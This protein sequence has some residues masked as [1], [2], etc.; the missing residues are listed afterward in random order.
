MTT[1]TPKDNSGIRPLIALLTIVFINMVGFGVVIPLLP[2]FA[3]ALEAD[4]WQ[5]TLLFAVFSLGQF[6]GEPF[7]GRLS[8]RIGRKPVLL[9]TMIVNTVCYAALALA[10]SI[11]IAIAIRLIN[12]FGA[13]NISTIQAYIADVS[14]PQRRAGR[15]GLIGAA[16]GLGFIIG[17]GMGGMLAK[18][19]EAQLA[20]QFP[21]FAAAL[22]SGMASL[23]VIVLLRESRTHVP[24]NEPPWTALDDAV[25]N[26]VISRVLLVSIIYMAGFSGMEACFGLW[27]QRR[28]DWGAP[29]VG[30]CFMAVGIVAAI[31]QGLLTGRLARRFGEARMLAFGVVLFGSM[32]FLQVINTVELMVPVLMGLGAFGMSNAMPNIA[33]IISR[34]SPPERQGAMLGLN[35]AA[36]AGARVIG[37]IFAGFI[38]S[39]AGHN[40]PFWI[41][42]IMTIPAAAV[43]L[44]AGR[45]MRV[46]SGS[47]PFPKAE[48]AR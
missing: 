43:A 5:V 32:L 4:E 16:F 25:A 2:F 1:S 7:F 8:D 46:N 6:F 41:G 17:P 21:L 31:T 9:M 29:E 39:Y 24:P 34:S 35:M 27:A 11:W 42:A 15:M 37:P 30:W 48:R 14:S 18:L 40:W 23:G 12:G 22:L 33:S 13:G 47:H 3:R 36:S 44:S 19:G 10:P 28:F 20:F 45:I 26:P 38:Y